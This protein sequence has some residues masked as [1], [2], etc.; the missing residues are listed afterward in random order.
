MYGPFIGDVVGSRFEFNNHRSKDFELVTD[1]CKYTDDTVLTVAIMDW[2]LNSEVR[3]SYSVAKY[4]QKWGRKYSLPS[5]SILSSSEQIA[6][7]VLSLLR[8]SAI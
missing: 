1:E 3:D 4:L 7:I 2:A 5:I 8:A 6:S